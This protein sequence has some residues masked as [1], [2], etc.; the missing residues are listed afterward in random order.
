MLIAC[1]KPS[2]KLAVASKGTT[3]SV[4][5]Q[6]KVLAGFYPAKVRTLLLARSAQWKRSS[7]SVSKLPA[8]SLI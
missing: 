5:L 4:V 7:K 6:S 1:A 8:S 3:R 2:A